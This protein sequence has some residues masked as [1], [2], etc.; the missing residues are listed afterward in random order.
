MHK[1][2]FYL[3]PVL[4]ARHVQ[5]ALIT[6]QFP[7]SDDNLPKTPDAETGFSVLAPCN[8]S[9]QFDT[10]TRSAPL[11]V[12]MLL[13]RRLDT[14][15]LGYKINARTVI[16][17]DNVQIK[18]VAAEIQG[19]ATRGHASMV[20]FVMQLVLSALVMVGLEIAAVRP[21]VEAAYARP[22]D[23][24]RRQEKAD[25]NSYTAASAVS[26]HYF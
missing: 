11:V 14:A 22:D 17:V 23:G 6:T 12:S 25:T 10:G 19:N 2:I 26:T 18:P 16:G 5:G 13:G 4:W 21:H 15:V 1:C 7:C 20:A 24:P 3:V 9:L 8:G